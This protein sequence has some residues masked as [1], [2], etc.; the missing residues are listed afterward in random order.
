MATVANLQVLIGAKTT[1]F[2]KAITDVQK[3]FRQKFSGNAIKISDSVLTGITGLSAALAGLGV[4]A[5]RSAAQM[6]Q[7][8]KAFTTLL[9][10]ADLAKDFLAELERF[11]AA[12]PFELPGLLNASKRLL[13]FGFSAQQV[14]PILT[15]IGDSWHG[16]RRH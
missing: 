3:T 13:A 6:E 4:I 2:Q 8:E 1:G 5:V 12:T 16:R 7:T 11:A 14:I 15:A 10:S 9:K